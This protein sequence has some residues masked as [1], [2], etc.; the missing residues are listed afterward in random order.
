VPRS[1]MQD[2]ITPLPQYVFMAWCLV[3]HRD[4]FSVFLTIC[5]A[6]YFFEDMKVTIYCSVTATT[7]T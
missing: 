3:K 4:N 6:S 1:R 2:A 5:N 7:V